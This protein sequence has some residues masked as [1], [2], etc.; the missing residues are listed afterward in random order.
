MI[1]NPKPVTAISKLRHG[2]PIGENFAIKSIVKTA[3]KDDVARIIPKPCD[4]TFKISLANTGK[5]A[6]APPKNTENRSRLIAQIRILLLN[7]KS[8]PSERLFHIF[9]FGTNT[10]G[11]NLKR[12][13]NIIDIARNM[14]ITPKAAVIPIKP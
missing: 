4:P 2:L 9:S 11:Y 3:P 12:Y 10:G 8:I 5:R 7:T 13:I 1:D 6:T 14:S